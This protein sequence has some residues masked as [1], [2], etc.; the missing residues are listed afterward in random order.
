VGASLLRLGTGGDDYEVVCTMAS[1]VR[2]PA[3]FT[4]IGEVREGQGV[5]VRA[6]GRVVDPGE[7][8]WRH[9]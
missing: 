4:L 9:G 8:G 6:A 2:K 3:G 5:E 1:G 7:G